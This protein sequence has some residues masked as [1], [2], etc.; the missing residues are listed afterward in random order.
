MHPQKTIDIADT[1]F[2]G[3]WVLRPDAC[4]FPGRPWRSAVCRIEADEGAVRF[5]IDRTDADR[6]QS[7]VVYRVRADGVDQEVRI[8]GFCGT[9]R[10]HLLRPDALLC[11]IFAEGVEIGRIGRELSA[12][13]HTLT[14]TQRLQAGAVLQTVYTRADFTA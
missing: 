4:R 7:R 8:P 6:V 12:D 14:V 2:T 13:G 1:G 10:L 5:T 9:L 11:Q 3:Q